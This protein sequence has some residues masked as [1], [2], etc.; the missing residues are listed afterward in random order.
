MTLEVFTACFYPDQ[1]PIWRLAESCKRFGIKLT[2]YG[3]GEPY[4]SWRVMK[5]TKLIPE[6]ERS[7]ADVVMYTDGADSW[8]T[9]DPK[10]SLFHGR[11]LADHRVVI[12]AERNCWPYPELSSRFNVGSY[13]CAGQFVGYRKTV[14]DALRAAAAV[15]LTSEEQNDQASWLMAIATNRVAVQIDAIRYHFGDPEDVKPAESP[16]PKCVHFNGGGDKEARMKPWW[17]KTM[18]AASCG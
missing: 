16:L 3:M 8:F 14:L 15:K 2:P 1:R 18:G 12:A 7:R 11:S 10:P 9:G 6:I 17:E 5:L 13:P 4:Q